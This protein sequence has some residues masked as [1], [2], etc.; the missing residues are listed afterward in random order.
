MPSKS[1]KRIHTLAYGLIAEVARHRLEVP[2]LLDALCEIAD[3]EGVS[4]SIVGCGGLSTSQ[5]G[6]EDARLSP[7]DSSKSAPLVS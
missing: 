6:H 5:R 3:G 1:L 2:A 7:S 4:S